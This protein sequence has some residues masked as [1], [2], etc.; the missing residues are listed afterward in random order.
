MDEANIGFNVF[1]GPVALSVI[2]G[3]DTDECAYQIG[4]I[5]GDYKVKGVQVT[6]LILAAKAMGVSVKPEFEALHKRT[7]FFVA[8]TIIKIDGM[9]LLVL[10]DHYIVIE[11]KDCNIHLCDAHSKTIVNLNS[12]ARLMQ[13]VEKIF[14]VS[15]EKRYVKPAP[16]KEV[17][18]EYHTE[19][20]GGRVIIKRI[21]KFDDNT[22]KIYQ[23]GSFEAPLD[24]K[25]F[26]DIAFA[27]MKIA[28]R[29]MK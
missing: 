8:S 1:C 11:V 12:S 5:R 24:A 3:H 13:K 16:P 7:L 25:L 28:D 19:L 14:R 2:T 15:V 22:V 18:V 4:R 17:E 20:V 27:I 9:Y 21:H 23:M 10:K 6:D 26:Q 29:E